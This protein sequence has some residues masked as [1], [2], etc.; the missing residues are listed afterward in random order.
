MVNLDF[1]QFYIKEFFSLTVRDVL[2]LRSWSNQ[3]SLRPEIKICM[4][5]LIKIKSK[6]Y[7]VSSMTKSEIHVSVQRSMTKL[8]AHRAHASPGAHPLV[9]PRHWLG[10]TAGSA[11]PRPRSWLLLRRPAIGSGPPAQLDA[12][13]SA[14]SYTLVWHLVLK[15]IFWS[16]FKIN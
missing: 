10:R 13:Q 9:V 1:P 15:S 11:R 7:Y 5:K 14:R 8:G 4:N 16:S 12:A 2:K 3:H 6:P